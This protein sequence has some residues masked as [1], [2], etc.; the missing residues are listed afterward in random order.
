LVRIDGTT[1]NQDAKKIPIKVYWR[2]KNP[3]SEVIA[4]IIC[5]ESSIAYLSGG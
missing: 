1:P 5:P 3:N 4:G 2:M